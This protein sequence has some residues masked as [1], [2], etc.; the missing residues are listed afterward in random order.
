M[1]SPLPAERQLC[2][3]L[4]LLRS[5]TEWHTG[6]TPPCSAERGVERSCWTVSSIH[7]SSTLHIPTTLKYVQYFHSAALFSLCILLLLLCH[8]FTSLSSDLIWIFCG[9]LLL[10]YSILFTIYLVSCLPRTNPG[11]IDSLGINKVILGVNISLE[12]WMNTM[13]VKEKKLFTHCSSGI[14]STALRDCG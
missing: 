11:T 7:N 14:R 5:T 8:L 4:R 9:F 2:C 10:F 12:K 1:I 6:T 3:V 13:W